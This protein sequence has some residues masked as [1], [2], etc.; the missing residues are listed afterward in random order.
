[1]L[2]YAA[3]RSYDLIDMVVGD[4]YHRLFVRSGQPF[5]LRASTKQSNGQILEL[6]VLG[7]ERSPETADLDA[8]E[9]A[10]RRVFALDHSP[11]SFYDTLGGDA[12]LGPLII[13]LWGLRPLGGPNIFEMLVTAILGQQ[14]SMIAAHAIKQRLVLSLGATATVDGRVYHAFP[15]P[16][17]IAAAAMDDLLALK[18]SRRKAEYA[19]DLAAAIASGVLD[20]DALRGQP[21]ETILDSLLQIRGIGRWTAEYVLLRGY[22]YPDALPAGDAGLRRQVHK[23]YGLPA[24]PSEAEIIAI[25]ETWRPFRSWAT[26]YLWNAEW[27]ANRATGEVAE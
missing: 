14:I 12:V 20:L 19:R 8:A 22:G 26:L 10:L 27:A 2:R 3:R 15:T 23:Y 11:A 4:E 18:F 25:G 13:G 24:A 5:L 9:S 21:H 7:L 17:A 1:M 16:A 6:S